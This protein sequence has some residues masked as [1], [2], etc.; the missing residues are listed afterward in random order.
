MKTLI[1]VLA[2]I[3]A[4]L[5]MSVSP[6][7][8]SLGGTSTVDALGNISANT[9]VATQAMLP[10]V[11]GSGITPSITTDGATVYTSGHVLCVYSAASSSW[12]R[13]SDGSTSCTF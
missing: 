3:L 10:P 4:V 7:L 12:V 13:A 11:Q 2:F 1:L 6:P 9:F 8:A 5:I